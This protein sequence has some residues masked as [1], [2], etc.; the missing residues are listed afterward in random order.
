MSFLRIGDFFQHVHLLRELTRSQ[1]RQITIFGFTE[2]NP[3]VSLFPEFTFELVSRDEILQDLTRREL[4][5]YR[6]GWR[7]EKHLHRLNRKPWDLIINLSHTLFSARLM[8]CLS[9]NEK[10]GTQFQDGKSGGWNPWIAEM[11]N[12]WID[13]PKPEFTYVELLAQG[14]GISLP[15]GPPAERKGAEIWLQPLT[16]DPKKNWSLGSWR[17]LYQHLKKSNVVRVICAPREA[18]LLSPHFEYVD[19]LSFADIRQQ[20]KNC[21]LLVCGDTSVIHF[22]ALEGIPTLGLY[23]G[24]ANP[25]K[26]P[27]RQAQ[28][29][30]AVGEV[31]CWP[32]P[33][34]SPCTQTRH[35]CG[36]SLSV[37]H[38]LKLIHQELGGENG[39]RRRRASLEHTQEA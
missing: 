38:V 12:N 17:Q 26:T 10:W 4:P 18:E 11:N 39:Q 28:S 21:R 16:S 19:A 1:A 24:S 32:C 20:R 35:K 7:L 25:H 30:I 36:E 23:L 5:W 9:A 27:P 29:T 31:P 15:P 22:A 37:K 14:M 33:H 13:N 2:L 6:A 3:A 8:D 34:R